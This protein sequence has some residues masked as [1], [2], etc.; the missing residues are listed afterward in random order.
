MENPASK[1][2]PGECIWCRIE[3]P[4][5][6]GYAVSVV[7]TGMPGFLPSYDPITIGRVVPTTFVC[8]NG[9]RALFTYAFTMGTS[10][11]VQHSTASDEEI[12]FS[13]WADAYPKSISPK[14]AV[15]LF[16]PP[17]SSSPILIKLS[18]TR[19]G[20]IFPSLEETKFTG[21]MKIF[22]ESR[23]SRGA[24]ILLRGRAVG[25]LYTTKTFPD[26]YPFEIGMKKMMQDV[27]TPDVEADLEMYELPEEIVLSMSALFLGYL[28]Q[29]DDQLDNLS[30]ADKM[31]SHFSTRNETACFSLL[32]ASQTPLGNGKYKGTYTLA[33][34]VYSEEANYLHQLLEKYSDRKVQTHILPAAMTTE[35]VLFGYS[36]SSEQFAPGS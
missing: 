8:M 16:M 13:V 14:R 28:D 20:E 9:D 26:P 15:D 5:P 36:L 10:A 24:I 1:I 34:R 2:R 22:C 18:D 12:A 31:L 19:A 21:C 23:L 32:E 11:R 25:S 4:E 7:S 27:T 6:G 35:A 30:Y 33:D 3:S 17:I 29:P